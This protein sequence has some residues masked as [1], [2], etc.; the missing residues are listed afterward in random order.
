[1]KI[2]EDEI[3][4]IIKEV[5]LAGN[6]LINYSEFLAAT[7]PSDDIF[8][9]SMIWVLFKEFDVDNSDYITKE[10]LL[11]AFSKR[12]KQ[13]SQTDISDIIKKHDAAKNGRISFDEFASMILGEEE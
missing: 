2:P 5:D 10:N 13:L 11:E 12:G 6:G 4:Q 9:H 3:N 8:D 7:L 1:M